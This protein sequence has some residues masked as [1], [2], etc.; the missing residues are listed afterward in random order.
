ME[1]MERSQSKSKAVSQNTDAEVGGNT[2]RIEQPE[3]NW[4]FSG[5]RQ[6]LWVDSHKEY[7]SLLVHWTMT[8]SFLTDQ[9]QVELLKY[10][11]WQA[12]LC[13]EDLITGCNNQMKV[14]LIC[15]V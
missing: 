15:C 4:I 8:L 14:V 13:S 2:S 7:Y 3:A 5:H 10:I 6:G 12:K 9:A 11:T 1:F